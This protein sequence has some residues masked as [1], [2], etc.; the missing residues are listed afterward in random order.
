MI[1]SYIDDIIGFHKR[2]SKAWNQFNNCSL[3][4]HKLGLKPKL[5]KDKIPAQLIEVLGA[6]LDLI[7]Q[8]IYLPNDKYIRYTRNI[9]AILKSD[10]VTKQQLLSVCGQSR[11]CASFLP[12]L[13]ALVRGVE[14]Y[15]V[16]LK[17][18]N[19]TL[20]VCANLKNELKLIKWGLHFAKERGISFDFFLKQRGVADIEIYTDAAGVHGGIG[21]YT[22]VSFGRWFQLRWTDL[23]SFNTANI[24]I[25]W[26]E[27]AAVLVAIR[28]NIDLLRNKSVVLWCDNMPVVS[29]L[30]S[31][32][33]KVQRPDLQSLIGR[34]AKLCIANNV[35]LWLEHIP[36]KDNKTADALSRFSPDPFNH[37]SFSLAPKPTACLP[38][39]QELAKERMKFVINERDLVWTA[40]EDDCDDDDDI[41]MQT[42]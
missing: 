31:C 33:A 10:Q 26:K 8:R 29:M 13:K 38:I 22:H 5:A 16:T 18:L 2:K 40:D 6:L 3:I 25:Q 11:F 4:L 42:W 12:K 7:K 41:D 35:H 1:R 32:R 36:G 21:G 24:D 14:V 27:M 39:M 30:I 28:L 19:Q 17:R 34:I 9:D 23:C 37:L 20:N 15:A